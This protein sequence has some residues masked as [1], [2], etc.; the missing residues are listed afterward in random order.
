MILSLSINFIFFLKP[1]TLQK[2]NL[3][4]VL[5]IYDLLK[6]SDVRF[7]API[8]F[9]DML[10]IFFSIRN[11]LITICVWHVWIVIKYFSFEKQAFNRLLKVIGI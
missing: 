1:L 2:I 8:V 7:F 11:I 9:E 6:F 3:K 5:H 4:P 10:K